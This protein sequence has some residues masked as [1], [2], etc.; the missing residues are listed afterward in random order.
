MRDES[1]EQNIDI[2][3]SKENYYK[4]I[5][6]ASDDKNHQIMD[7]G[8]MRR[9]EDM[10]SLE[11]VGATY[12]DEIENSELLSLCSKGGCGENGQLGGMDAKPSKSD[13]L[14]QFGSYSNLT[15][16]T[17]WKVK[18]CTRTFH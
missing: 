17:F 5:S 18:V 11:R 3:G 16:I 1:A 8:L 13:N 15:L 10:V 2:S 12:A 7:Q 4:A 6:H 9:M 14:S